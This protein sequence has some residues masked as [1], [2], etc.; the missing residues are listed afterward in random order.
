MSRLVQELA[1]REVLI[2]TIDGSSHAAVLQEAGS[3]W[4]A[5]SS[6]LGLRMFPQDSI[7]LI[8]LPGGGMTVQAADGDLQPSLLGRSVAVSSRALEAG[9]SDTGTLEAFDADW[10]RVGI[11]NAQLYFQI[12]RIMEMRLR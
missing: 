6:A 7:R 1:G 8:K 4:I 12:G 9:F 2:W 11:E 3:R 10:L 5:A